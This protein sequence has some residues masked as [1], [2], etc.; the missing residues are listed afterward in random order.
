ML[1]RVPFREVWSCGVSLPPPHISGRLD[2]RGF[3]KMCSQNLEG[4][5]VRGQNLENKGFIRTFLASYACRLAL[6]IICSLPG[7][8]QVQM[9][10]GSLWNPLTVTR[11]FCGQ[12]P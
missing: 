4:A 9:S 1:K 12:K 5:E 6:T 3:S 7:M 2:W 8:G 11:H 10:H